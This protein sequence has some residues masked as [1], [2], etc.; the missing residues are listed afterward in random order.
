MKTDTRNMKERSSMVEGIKITIDGATQIRKGGGG[1][2]VK[3]GR[4]GGYKDYPKL[5]TV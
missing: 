4:S 2:G 5:F 3:K 1:K